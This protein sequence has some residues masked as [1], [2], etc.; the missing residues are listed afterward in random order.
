MRRLLGPLSL[1]G[2]ALLAV[3]GSAAA[4]SPATDARPGW[5]GISY[6]ARSARR[7][8]EE[9]IIITDVRRGSPAADAGIRPGDRLVSI[10]DQTGAERLMSL[11]RRSSLRAGQVVQMRI[12]RDGRRRDVSV[13]AS[14]R[15]LELVVDAAVELSLQTDSMVETMFRAMDSLRVHILQTSERPVVR[16]TAPR[17]PAAPRPSSAGRVA[18][19]E[20]VSA[21]FEFFV[22]RGERYDSLVREMEQLNREMARLR[23]REDERLQ[24]LR[25]Q[26]SARDESE[27]RRLAD[28]RESMQ[29]VSRE[30]ARLRASMAES[31]RA[32]AGWEYL[33]TPDPDA[34]PEAPAPEA[35]AFRPL[36]PY[37]L[38]SNRVAGAQVIEVQ[39][40]LG[41]YFGVEGG[42]L[43]VDVSPGTPAAVAGLRPGDVVTRLDQVGVRSV[44][45]FRFGVSQA[46]DTLPLTLVRQ[47]ASLQ[48]LLR[49][50]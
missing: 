4:Q 46:S 25:R 32:S 22:F 9:V 44:E 35:P 48:V 24:E 45:D 12:E 34:P 17:A 27:D 11:P 18:A 23:V 28:L 20:P 15:P 50:R 30:S 19:P 36:T 39:P 42:V 5:I 14:E 31:A 29:E 1:S 38:G 8:G 2:L 47:G 49:R 26:R 43:V 10:D 16:V 41:A 40:E 37:L 7:G 6:E 33:L 21:P 13:R 3:V